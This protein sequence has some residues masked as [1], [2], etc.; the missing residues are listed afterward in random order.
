MLN[1]IILNDLTEWVQKN[2][3]NDETVNLLKP[4]NEKMDETYEKV[5]VKPT[6]YPLYLPPKTNRKEESKI[7][8]VIVQTGQNTTDMVKHKE[9]LDI[10]LSFVLWNPGKYE[11]TEE[12][13]TFERNYEGWNDLWKLIDLAKRKIQSEVYICGFKLDITTPM[14]SGMFNTDEEVTKYPYWSG[15]LTF[16]VEFGQ[17]ARVQTKIDNFL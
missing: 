16:T 4:D 17:S 13:K 12:E 15:Y 6:A 1:T 3:C 2:I 9:R 11:E 8:A 5:Y 10:Q 14:K 7:P